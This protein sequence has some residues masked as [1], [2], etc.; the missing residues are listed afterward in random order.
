ME[1]TAALKR[2]EDFTK[3]EQNRINKATLFSIIPGGGQ[4]F[5]KQLFKGIV[6][7]GIFAIFL[8]QLFGFG[9]EAIE[10]LIT[11]GTTPRE[12][13]SLF[14]MIEGVLEYYLYF[15][16]WFFMSLTFMMLIE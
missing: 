15:F 16:S 7:L 11:L 9:I 4:I 3:E 12:D 10:G 14:L 6:F 1:S 8:L 2:K 13:H 5:N